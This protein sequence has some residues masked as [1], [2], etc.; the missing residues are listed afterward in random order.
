MV[1]V[2]SPVDSPFF[3]RI[4][5]IVG[6]GVPSGV[7]LIMPFFVLHPE[8]SAVAAAA[9]SVIRESAEYVLANPPMGME[10]ILSFSLPPVSDIRVRERW[11][12]PMPSPIISTTFLG[13]SAADTTDAAKSIN[14]RKRTGNLGLV[15]IRTADITPYSIF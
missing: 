11:A 12:T 4:S 14:R 10:S 7:V 13:V 2:T 6:M 15:L 3:C 1:V 5:S 8:A 9:E